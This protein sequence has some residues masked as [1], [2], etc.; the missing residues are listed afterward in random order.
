MIVQ[1]PLGI[2]EANCYLVYDEAS[3]E[4][5][6]VDP[7]GDTTPLRREIEQR[8]VKIQAILNT[9]GHF[10]HS[11]GNAELASFNVPLGI[12]PDD[13]DLLAEGG[14]A[15]W[16]G[17][18]KVPTMHPSIELTEGFE[19]AVGNLR[20]HTLTTPGH[21]PGSVC[22]YIREENALLTG[23]TLFAGG[24][25]RSDLPGGDPRALTASLTRL[26]TLPPE[27]IIYPGHGPTSTLAHE[28]RD[29]PWLRL[30]ATR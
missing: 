22:F 1:I 28:K 20:L 29:N 3:G 4:G 5:V 27:T 16:F 23:D 15:A 14:G 30:I 11:A 24:I 25:G 9:H 18:P 2:L 10:D 13:R 19:Y 6:I 12:H 8:H 7:G 21:T 26:L 17:F